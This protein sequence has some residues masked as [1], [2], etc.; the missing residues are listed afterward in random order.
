VPLVPFVPVVPFVPFVPLVPVS[1]EVDPVA[2]DGDHLFEFAELGKLRDKL[3][4]VGWIQRV[5]ILNL[6]HEEIQEHAFAGR[7]AGQRRVGCG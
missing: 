2:A 1:P 3:S 7:A 6:S 5:L 4:A